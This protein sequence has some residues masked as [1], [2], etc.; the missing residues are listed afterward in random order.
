MLTGQKAQE[1]SDASGTNLLD[2]TKRQWSQEILDKL[3]IDKS[4]LPPLVDSE[5][6]AGTITKEIA[7]LTGLKEGTIVAG[8]AGDNA[9]AALGTGVCKEGDA[10]VRKL[11]DKEKYIF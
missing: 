8:G 10:F 11:R 3:S 5:A 7:E 6:I 2:I 9:A 1:I 4:L